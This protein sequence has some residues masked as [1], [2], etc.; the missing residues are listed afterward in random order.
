MKKK[1]NHPSEVEQSLT[2]KIV[3][4]LEHVAAK[5]RAMIEKA[6]DALYKK[7]EDE[8]HAKSKEAA[9]LILELPQQLN[10][11]LSDKDKALW[12]STIREVN[13]FALVAKKLL[14]SSSYAGMGAILNTMG[15]KI[16]DRNHLE[17][18]IDN[19]KRQEV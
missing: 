4:T 18:I 2:N 15:D 1:I 14:D 5:Y 11:L 9:E 12:D 19:L 3:H 6:D 13:A 8:Y 10:A 16:N 17:Q 7:N